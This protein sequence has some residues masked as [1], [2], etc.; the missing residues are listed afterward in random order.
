MKIQVTYTTDSAVIYLEYSK[1]NIEA[2]KTAFVNGSIA[3]Y[4]IVG[5]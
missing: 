5:A 4:R 2:V 3:K 1:S